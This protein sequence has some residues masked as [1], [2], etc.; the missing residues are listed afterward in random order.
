MEFDGKK[1]YELVENNKVGHVEKFAQAMETSE[2]IVEGEGIASWGKLKRWT[3]VVSDKL[4]KSFS[5]KK[6]I[7]STSQWDLDRYI[8]NNSLMGLTVS[9]EKNRSIHRSYCLHFVVIDCLHVSELFIIY[10]VNS[11]HRSDCLCFAVILIS[12]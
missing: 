11:I 8:I 2:K 1:T 9:R 4:T 12:R 7:A 10:L 5:F 6:T 3:R